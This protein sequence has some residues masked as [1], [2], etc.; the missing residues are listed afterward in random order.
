MHQPHILVV[1]GMALLFRSFFATAMSNQF[2]YNEQGLPTNAVQGF[3]RHVMTARSIFNPSH[4]VITW[5]KGMHT[6]RNELF[7]GYKNQSSSTPT[8]NDSTV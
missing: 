2:F 6:F 5:D 3:A 7:E 1:D 4:V 8:G